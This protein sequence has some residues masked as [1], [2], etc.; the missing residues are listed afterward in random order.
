[1]MNCVLKVMS[2]VLKMIYF[3]LKRASDSAANH[4]VL[5][6]F[7]FRRAAELGMTGNVYMYVRYAFDVNRSK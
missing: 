1:M 3:V 5:D 7:L 2:F 6:E 4:V